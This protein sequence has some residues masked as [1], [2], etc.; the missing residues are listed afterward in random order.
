MRSETCPCSESARSFWAQTELEFLL[1]CPAQAGSIVCCPVLE[2]SKHHSFLLWL[3]CVS[4]C[5]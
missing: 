5:E 1:L 2:L 4:V 3:L